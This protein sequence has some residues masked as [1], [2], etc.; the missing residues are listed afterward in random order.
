MRSDTIGPY[1][2]FSFLILQLTT[3]MMVGTSWEHFSFQHFHSLFSINHSRYLVQYHVSFD[4]VCAF[5]HWDNETLLLFEWSYYMHYMNF[6][7]SWQNSIAFENHI[8]ILY[9]NRRLHSIIID[10]YCTFSFPI[11]HDHFNNGG[12]KFTTRWL[13]VEQ[14]CTLDNWVISLW[15]FVV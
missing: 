5:N 14:S 15:W 3:S 4:N 6:L 12:D 8:L 10:P 9:F 7:E 1:C 2:T 13:G 11:L